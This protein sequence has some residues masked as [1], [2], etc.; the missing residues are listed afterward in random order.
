MKKERIEELI[1]TCFN[2]QTG[3]L[4][5]KQI[6]SRLSN[7]DIEINIKEL[8]NALFLLVK[9]NKLKLV[10]RNKYRL[11]QHNDAN[12][13][14]KL[15]F[16][17][18]GNA[19]FISEQCAD[20]FI[21]KSNVLN[22]LSNDTVEIKI[23]PQR[24]RKKEGKVTKI[25]ERA[26]PTFLA[27]VVY[28]NA[29]YTIVPRGNS[30]FPLHQIQ[31]DLGDYIPVNEDLL[32]LRIKDKNSGGRIFASIDKILGKVGEHETEMHAII[33]EFGFEENFEDD[34][35]AESEKIDHQ[36]GSQEI[37]QRKDLRKHLTFTIDPF[38]AKDFDDAISYHPT[39][40]GL[41]IGVHIADVSHYVLPNTALDKE[42]ARRATSV[43]LV[44][45]TVPMLPEVLSNDLC[46][47][48]PNID[49]LAFSILFNFDKANKII[50]FEVCKSVIH[51][52]KRFTYEQAQEIIEGKKDQIFEIAINKCN[53]LALKMQ[54]D[55]FEQ[56]AVNFETSEVSFILDA[57]GKPI[58]LETKIRK[59]A[60][61]MIEE[62]MLLANRTIAK[63]MFDKGKEKGATFVYRTH[64]E[65]SQEKLVVLKGIAKRFGYHLNIDQLNLLPK[66][67][68]KLIAAVK[69][70]PEESL[71]Q[72]L[73]IRSMAKAV[74][75]TQKTAHFGLAF[76]YYSHFTSPIR[77]YPDL[78]CHRWL[79]AFLSKPIKIADAK[80][81]EAQA[82]HCSNMEQK[83]TEAERASIKYKQAEFLKDHI[84]ESFNAVVTGITDWGIYAEIPQFKAEGMIRLTDVS[85][86][87]Y[88]FNEKT[89]S[90][91]S[92]NGRESLI[93]GQ[94]ILVKVMNANPFERR[95]DLDWILKK[96]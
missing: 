30:F 33:S 26:S 17:R 56:G 9:Q 92:K 18:S 94:E 86:G 8:E 89:N 72:N 40:K 4:N 3:L 57:K 63:M 6:F 67:I 90:L 68:N 74:Y 65:P 36:I 46:S 39:E 80:I 50:D 1:L 91:F 62:W 7:K 76:D 34:V 53:E 70:K 28:K 61:K 64:D 75:T 2:E 55:R 16:T 29:K 52:D 31:V 14:G 23:L 22:A 88:Y 85:H 69:D 48:K 73:A 41:T 21:A 49:R 45:R 84:G 44:D 38:N 79:H 66:E 96:E 58:G 51:S 59:D 13:R 82:K 93:F 77:R 12:L 42:A 35:I 43:Y 81:L 25:I 20:V 37:S 60:H 87:N 11:Q 24:G 10:D 47:L 83:A 32:I 78:L 5:T 15:D 71:I 54:A 27:M 95:I 19:Y